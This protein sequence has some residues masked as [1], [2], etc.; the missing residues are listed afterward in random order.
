MTGYLLKMFGY[1]LGLTLLM[2]L[3]LGIFM[4]MRGRKSLLLMILVNLLTNPAA[5][6]V[7]WLGL[8]QL[9]VEM[10]VVAAEAVVYCV[11]A[12]K[13]KWKISH[14]VWLSVATNAV[15]WI[16]GILLQVWFAG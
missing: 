6:F 15:S 10:V 7:C 1:S 13:G 4:G 12:Q 8:P 14:P 16:G 5:V 11:F 2:E 3:P 9:P